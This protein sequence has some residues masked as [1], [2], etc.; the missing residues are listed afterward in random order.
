MIEFIILPSIKEQVEKI[1]SKQLRDTLSE[2]S[3]SFL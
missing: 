2:S 1:V 3:P